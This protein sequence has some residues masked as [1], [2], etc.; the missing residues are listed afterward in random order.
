MFECVGFELGVHK[1]GAGSE[2]MVAGDLSTRRL[3]C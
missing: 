1:E 2:V 3:V